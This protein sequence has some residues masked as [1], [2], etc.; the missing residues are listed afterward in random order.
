[1]TDKIAVIDYGGQYAHLI[2]TKI[3]DI[4]VYSEIIDTENQISNLKDF[5][6]IILSGSPALSSDNE[7]KVD[8]EI[9]KFGIPILGF[10]FGHQEIAKFHGGKVERKGQE[11]GK[12]ILRKTKDSDIFKELNNEEIVWMNHGDSVTD[13]GDMDEIGVSVYQDNTIQKY[14]AIEHKE[15][16]HYG[17]QFHPEVENTVN[18]EK[19]FKNFCFNICKCKK[20]WDSEKILKQIEMEIKEKNINKKIFMLVSGGVDSTVAAIILSKTIDKKNIIY[21]HVDTGLMRK[22]ES[23]NVLNLFEKE[24]LKKNIV[25]IDAKEQFLNA[26]KNVYIAEEKRKIIGDLFIKILKKEVEKMGLDDFYLAQGTIY[27]DRIETGET[28]FA[29]KI[30]THHNRVPII[31][32]MIVEGKVIEPLKDLYKK[33]VRR[34]GIKLGIS[35]ELI[36]R[37]P[38]PG[39][40]LGIRCICSDYISKINEINE[41]SESLKKKY[42]YIDILPIKSVGVKGDARSYEYPVIFWEKFESWEKLDEIAS[43]IFRERKGVNRFLYLFNK[44][45]DLIFTSTR[46]SIDSKRIKLLQ[47]A[48]YIVN[49]IISDEGLYENIWQMP[50]ILLPTK[51]NKNIENILVIRPINSDRGMTASFYPLSIEVIEKIKKQ[52]LKIGI[53][54]IAVD[55]SSKPPATI[56]W[57]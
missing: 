21:L 23:V 32:K 20:S 38:F 31:E 37:H 13:P 34:I 35:E 47:E 45:E 52:I 55:I 46:S 41:L 50:I 1:M 48:D 40:G 33:E 29:R 16:K 43:N 11:Y 27:P 57:E 42:K 24:S 9:L 22:N 44:E 10:C 6:G 39:P 7:I 26:L 14:S 56:E 51:I 36:N 28:K 18:G 54:Y 12:T 15:K 49:K 5:K 30:K 25:F 2:A 17:F 4:G 19:M 8:L 53:K 3:R